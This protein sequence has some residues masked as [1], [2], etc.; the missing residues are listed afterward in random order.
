MINRKIRQRFGPEEDYLLAVQVNADA[1]YAAGHGGINKPWQSVAE[2]LNSSPNVCMKSIKGVTAKARFKT[3]LD[4]H[5][6]WEANSAQKSGTDEDE[7]PFVQIMT[8]LVASITDYEATTA[9]LAATKKGEKEA[10]EQSGEVV[11]CAAVS[12]IKLGKRHS[13]SGSD[14]EEKDEGFSRLN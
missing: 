4:K 5:R 3:L 10:K 7:T 13:R 11:R 14:S 2:K 12:R 6:T 1:P 8:E 9:M